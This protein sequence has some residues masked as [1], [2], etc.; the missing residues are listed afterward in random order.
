MLY[1][2]KSYLKY[3]AKA[4]NRHGVHSPFVYDFLDHCLYNKT[5]Y[6]AYDRLKKNRRTLLQNHHKITITDFGAGSRIFTSNTRKISAI[7]K[8]AGIPFKKQKILFRLVHYFKP[9]TIIELGTSLGLAT[10]AMSLGNPKAT[11]TTVEGCAATLQVAKKQFA[12]FNLTN[13]LPINAKFEDFFKTQKS[14]NW[15]FMYIDGN[16]TK[17]HTLAYFTWALKHVHNDSVLIFDDIYWSKSM[18]EAWQ[19]IKEHPKV[20][21]SIDTF[22]W[23][24]IFFRKEQKKQHF[25]IRV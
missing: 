4:T 6:P 3:L 9:K 15:D 22:F 8:H 16:H 2:L 21:V 5:T 11:I 7:A 1:P 25:T 24:L 18:T 23:G 13:I 12:A 20:T 10:T 19:Q 14:Q 17:E